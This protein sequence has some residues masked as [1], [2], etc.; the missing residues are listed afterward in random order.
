MG[1]RFTEIS[2]ILLCFGAVTAYM[3]LIGN[4]MNSILHTIG[5]TSAYDDDLVRIIIIVAFL[6]LVWFPTCVPKE[7]TALRYGSFLSV[8]GIVYISI[9]VLI[10]SPAY[11]KSNKNFTKDIDYFNIDYS[12]FGAIGIAVFAYDAVQNVPLIYDELQ[13]RNP[14]RMKKVLFRGTALLMVLYLILGIMGYLSHVG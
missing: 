9:L 12:I 7:I 13:Y 3:V 4:I 10:Q 6:V 5:I 1:R 8:L 14:R 2:I 11:I